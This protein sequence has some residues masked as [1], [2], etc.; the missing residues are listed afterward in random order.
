MKSYEIV[1][2]LIVEDNP[3]D[4]E[5]AIRALKKGNLSNKIFTVENGAEAIEYLNCTGNYSDRCAENKPKVIFLDLKLPKINGLEV[6]KVIKSNPNL[7]TIPV[8][9][10]TSSSEDPDIN[11]AY[12]L[13]ANSYVVKPVDFDKFIES[14]KSLG[15]YW[16]L[17]NRPLV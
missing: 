2:I 12:K 10:L 13:G 8:V 1:D 5:L 3:N 14:V 16:L 6:L 4:A 11:E 7:K 17:I 15:F 9:I